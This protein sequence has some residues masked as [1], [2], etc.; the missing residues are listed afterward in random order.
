M[1]IS[2]ITCWPPHLRLFINF[3]QTFGK[4]P[5]YLH[6]QQ[7]QAETSQKETDTN[8]FKPKGHYITG[9]ERQ[10]L[11]KVTTYFPAIFNVSGGD[12]THILYQQNKT[13]M[14]ECVN[15][16]GLIILTTYVLF[17]WTCLGYC[18]LV[19]VSQMKKHFVCYNT[20]SVYKP[21]AACLGSQVNAT[22]KVLHNTLLS[23]C[24]VDVYG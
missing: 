22:K 1:H 14:T 21:C 3:L 5:N 18:T 6:R 11:L 17:V 10:A 13:G 16:L 15:W 2:D 19:V 24:K 7:L 20:C 12:Y 4:I 23:N 9:P 8:Q